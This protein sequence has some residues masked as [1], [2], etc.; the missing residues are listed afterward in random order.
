MIR[1]ADTLRQRFHL[2]SSFQRIF[3]VVF[4]LLFLGVLLIALIIDNTDG[5]YNLPVW[6]LI[7]V[8]VLFALPVSILIALFGSQEI[9]SPIK[10]LMISAREIARGNFDHKV[11]V[12]TS[13]EMRQL[14]QIFN[15]MTIE[16]K[17]INQI[18]INQIIREK[19][20]TEAILRH[21]ADG[22]IVT[23]PHDEILM[24]NNIVEGWFNIKESVVRGA[25]MAF[26]FPDLK[27]LVQR[28]KQGNANAL[29]KDEIEIQPAH[30]P[31]KI[32]LA[33]HASQVVDANELIAIVIVLRNITLE[34]QVDQLKTE[35]V[36]V[37]AHELRSPLTSIAG[38]SEI[39]KDPELNSSVR[40]EY[41]DIIH[42]ESGRLAELINRFLDISRIENGQTPLVRIPVD[43]VGVIS[44]VLS[45]HA[46]L[47]Q[48]KN[49][50][51]Q[52]DAST[53]VP[54]AFA[55]PDLIGQVSLNLFSNAVKYSPDGATV[56]I[57]VGFNK[58]EISVAVRDTGY[59]ISQENLKKLFH[60]FFRAKD[61]KHVKETE[62]TGLG[63]AFVKEIIQQHGGRVSVKSELGEGSTFGFT[64]PVYTGEREDTEPEGAMTASRAKS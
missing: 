9:S 34:K 43:V 55:D 3:I 16:L 37:V 48:K 10:K 19:I 54:N 5:G 53:T 11:D 24:I 49:I 33:A 15:Y 2:L 51:V 32:V 47:A 1:F 17:R 62:G 28:T 23:G 41:I 38:F 31:D 42:Y 46:P 27:F 50:A 7:L 13:E 21:I 52:F 22:V 56:T 26:L 40:K 29:L 25:S 4:P 30:G 20:K 18:N 36:H 57:E 61:D 8:P 58:K 59:G 14:S 63:L 60:K 12:Q 44:N 35:L 45:I 39:I 6:M 64:L